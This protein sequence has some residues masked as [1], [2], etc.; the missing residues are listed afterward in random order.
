MLLRR[1]FSDGE[2]R[3]AMFRVLHVSNVVLGIVY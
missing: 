2:Y 3:C 1:V